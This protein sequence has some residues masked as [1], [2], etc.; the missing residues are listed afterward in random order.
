MFAIVSVAWAA[1][2]QTPGTAKPADCGLG[3]TILK[4]A[5]I[6]LEVSCQAKRGESVLILTDKDPQR[7]ACAAALEA[8]AV[9]LGLLPMIMDLSAY[10]KRCNGKS[11][12]KPEVLKSLVLK[13]VKSAAE[14][15]DIVI[16]IRSPGLT[17]KFAHIFGI[18]YYDDVCLTAEQR[19][20]EF[21]YTNMERWNIT[22]EAVAVLR[23]RTTWLNARLRS[24]KTVHIT[25]PAGTDLS[26]PMNPGT[27]W[28][29]IL[30]IIPLYGEVAIVPALGPGTK[31]VIAIDGS[32][33][34]GIRPPKE[35]DRQPLR[36]VMKD[37]RVESVSGDPEQVA[38][39][40]DRDAKH[41]PPGLG[42]D[43]VGL[44]TTSI[45]DNDAYWTSGRFDNGTHTHNTIHIALGK[46]FIREGVVHG[47]LHMDMD[48]YRPT[49]SLDGLVV[50]RDG[51]FVD[52]VLKK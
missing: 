31:G 40:K 34:Q 30:G 8:A 19:C 15:A 22:P 29:P 43:E 27:R 9:Q 36:V 45:P 39:L 50:I 3:A 23:P 51:V 49:V 35:T 20:M 41:D 17:L 37:G 38:R 14:A 16:C 47:R 6:T 21:Q 25:S 11:A 12:S 26:V 10:S 5:R 42:L 28:Y 46:N 4:N 33:Y 48:L 32:T 2:P 1:E 13:P 52:S 18:P 24:T 7:S 44:V